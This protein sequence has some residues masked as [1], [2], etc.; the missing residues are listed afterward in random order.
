MTN[1][2]HDARHFLIDENKAVT[3]EAIKNNLLGI[4]DRKMLIEVF[5]EHNDGIAAQVPFEYP[6]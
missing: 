3:V 5:R 6:Y 2:V 1:K 4:D